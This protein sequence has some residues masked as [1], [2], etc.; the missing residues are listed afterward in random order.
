MR[1]SDW[2]SDV[3]S[4]DLGAGGGHALRRQAEAQRLLGAGLADRAG[5]GDETGVAARAGSGAEAPQRREAVADD[6]QRQRF[7]AAVGAPVPP[8]C[9]AIRSASSRERVWQSVLILG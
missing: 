7:L 3:C 1:I 2:S 8:R 6:P 9:R 4:S 5:D